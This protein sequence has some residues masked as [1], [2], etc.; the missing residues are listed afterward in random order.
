MRHLP[1]CVELPVSLLESPQQKAIDDFLVLVKPCFK[2][3]NV[4]P[5]Q[6]EL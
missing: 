5:C 4:P 1:Y 6:R 2:L 3:V